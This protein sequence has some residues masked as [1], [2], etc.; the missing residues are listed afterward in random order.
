VDAAQTAGVLPVYPEEMGADLLVAA[1]H[2]SLYGPAGGGLLYVR[3]GLMLETLLEGGTGKDSDLE[4]QP[5]TGPDRYEAGTPN[6]LG[7]VGLCAGI[8]LVE[9]TGLE[10][11]RSHDQAL[12]AAF[13]E[14]LAAVPRAK[15]YGPLSPEERL[16]VISINIQS[17]AP[18]Q[19]GFMLDRYYGIAVRTGLHCAPL[20]HKTIGTFPSGTV[21]F[22]FSYQNNLDQ[23]EIAIK[24]LTAIAREH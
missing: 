21:R 23:I 22:S 18:D 4:G 12:T 14:G 17:M 10:K 8:D 6:L 24:A 16:G 11:I 19:V 1:A 7:I 15:S 2:K 9:K 5:A 20:A 3:P 13:M